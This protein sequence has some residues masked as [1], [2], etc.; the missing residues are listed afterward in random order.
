MKLYTEVSPTGYVIIR[1]DSGEP[2]FWAG[3]SVYDSQ[4]T[5]DPDSNGALSLS[6]L[7]KFAEQTGREMAEELGGV[8]DRVEIVEEA[9]T[10]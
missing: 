2:I 3:N 8:F 6:M 5:V 7:V 9:Q 1:D 4:S 10:Y